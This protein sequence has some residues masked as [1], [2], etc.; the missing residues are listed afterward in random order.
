M[1]ESTV[2]NLSMLNV[3]ATVLVAV[4]MI[5]FGYFMFEIQIEYI[6]IL[7]VVI[8]GMGVSYHMFLSKKRN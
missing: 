3:F 4:L 8:F 5:Y 1:D 2:E 7:E 6:I